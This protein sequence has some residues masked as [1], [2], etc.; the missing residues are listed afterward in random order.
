MLDWQTGILVFPV[1]KT[2][3]LLR[4]VHLLR[5]ED[6]PSNSR[7]KQKRL[8]NM[9]Q[10]CVKLQTKNETARISQVI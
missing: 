6:M 9:M 8:L 5:F 3:C 7:N 10:V 4:N 2:D 1:L